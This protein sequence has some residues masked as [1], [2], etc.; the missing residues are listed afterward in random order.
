MY[1]QRSNLAAV[2]DR[3]IAS[4][5][6]KFSQ[7]DEAIHMVGDET[8]SVWSKL[9]GEAVDGSLKGTQLVMIPSF[10]LFWFAWTNFYSDTTIMGSERC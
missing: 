4:R 7:A 5:V 8:G 6:L 9:D 1:E 2:F 10:Q 3:K